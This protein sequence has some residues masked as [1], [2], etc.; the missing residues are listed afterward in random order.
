MNI[1]EVL[2]GVYDD[3]IG[4]RPASG[5]IKPVH[6]ANGIVRS[7][8]GRYY[9][10][11][12]LGS[13]AVWWKQKNRQI[14]ATRTFEALASRAR[15]RLGDL[16]LDKELFEKTR[17]FTHGILATDRAL[18]PSIDHSSFSLT[19]GRIATRDTSDYGLGE[20]GAFL[21]GSGPGSLRSEVERCVMASKPGDPISALVWPL[22]EDEEGQ[23]VGEKSSRTARIRRASSQKHNRAIFEELQTAAASLASHERTQG[24]QLRTLQ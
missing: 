3:D 8:Q 10:L 14:D 18:F 17:R 9:D 7:V 2:N 15:A 5:G 4:W 19:S 11:D 12:L 23:E 24:N 6:V 16:A 22:L 21:L 20:L 1:G 13:F